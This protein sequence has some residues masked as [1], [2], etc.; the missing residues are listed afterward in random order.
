MDGEGA[1]ANLRE[2][3]LA[4]GWTQEDL[5]RRSGVSRRTICYLES[6]RVKAQAP[7]RKKLLAALGFEWSRHVDVFGP[8][9]SER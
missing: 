6:G 4:R 2:L 3:R 7:T 1:G 9:G 8:L 5:E